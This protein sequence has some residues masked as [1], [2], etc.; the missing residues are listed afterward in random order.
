MVLQQPLNP[1][2]VFIQRLF[3]GLQRQNDVTI[4]PVALLF[5]T[6]EVGHEGRCHVFVVAGAAPV[7]IAVLLGELEWIER[8]VR[9]IC[10]NHVDMRQQQDRLAGAGAA[11]PRH[12][13]ALARRRLEHLHVR[14]VEACGAKP[15]R[16]RIGGA[17]GIAGFGDRVRRPVAV[18]RSKFGQVLA[19]RSS[20]STAAPQ[21]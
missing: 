14:P 17:P 2:R 18:E 13:I 16:H 20:P 1:Q 7:V 10:R 21:T 3:V 19:P 11:Q 4:G 15:C 12:Q 6:N 5:V 9:G 8:P